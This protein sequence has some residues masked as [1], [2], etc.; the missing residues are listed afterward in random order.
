MR[1]LFLALLLVFSAAL[2]P[3]PDNPPPGLID[4]P[5]PSPPGDANDPGEVPIDMEPGLISGRL[6]ELSKMKEI[7]VLWARFKESNIT[8]NT[9]DAHAVLLVDIG[10]KI[11][12][13][14]TRINEFIDRK[15]TLHSIL[16]PS[17]SS[18]LI[19][20]SISI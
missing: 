1:I 7:E 12:N 10:I 4:N 8:A 3:L 19:W 17:L 20:V 2:K 9:E 5:P 11:N 16:N 18:S 15:I 6:D 13:N 14:D